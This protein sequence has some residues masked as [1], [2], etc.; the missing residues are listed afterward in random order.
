[1]NKPIAIDEEYKESV[2]RALAKFEAKVREVL[3]RRS[4]KKSLAMNTGAT[5]LKGQP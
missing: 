3:S 2:R 1:M 4:T 5:G